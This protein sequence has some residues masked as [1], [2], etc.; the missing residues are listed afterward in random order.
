[1][2]TNLQEH[3]V[4]EPPTTHAAAAR[5]VCCVQPGQ[6]KNINNMLSS[7]PLGGNSKILAPY[8]FNCFWSKK[9]SDFYNWILY[10]ELLRESKVNSQILFWRTDNVSKEWSDLFPSKK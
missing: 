8:I 7:E 3:G 1:M 6:R 9:A 4:V 5:R 2:L 10:V